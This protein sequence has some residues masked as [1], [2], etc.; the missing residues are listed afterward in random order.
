MRTGAEAKIIA[1]AMQIK[2]VQPQVKIMF[3]LNS[4]M[5][6]IMYDLHKTMEANPEWWMKDDAGEY[7]MLAGQKTFDLSVEG[8]RNAWLAVLQNAKVSGA[9]DGAFLDRGNTYGDML[10]NV[11]SA[12]QAA[13]N[14]GHDLIEAGAQAIF[15]GSVVILNNANS[16]KVSF[17]ALHCTALHMHLPVLK[18]H[19][20]PSHPIPPHPI[21]FLDCT[22]RSQ[23]NGRMYER[24]GASDID[25]ATVM[26]DI[27]DL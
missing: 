8:C 26:A 14:A 27:H 16:P 23:V 4:V 3:Y 11:S 10:R 12:R 1:A 19:P 13:W 6:W 15:N 21:P 24:W 7:I 2:A 18:L 5:D 22:I 9:I 25:H 20:T 17:F